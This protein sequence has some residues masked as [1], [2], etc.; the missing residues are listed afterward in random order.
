MGSGGPGDHRTI[1]VGG[2]GAHTKHK[3]TLV[4]FVGIQ[5]KLRELGGL[6]ETQRQDTRRQR[7]KAAGMARLGSTKKA[8]R[9]LE[10]RIR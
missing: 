1:G 9:L 4:P 5:Q 6:A 3:G 8:L 10:R 2:V 7:V